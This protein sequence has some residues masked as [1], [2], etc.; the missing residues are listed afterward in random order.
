MKKAMR[1]FLPVLAIALVVAMSG[2]AFAQK[3]DP[4]DFINGTIDD[5]FTTNYFSNNGVAGAPHGTFRATNDGSTERSICANVYVFDDSQEMKECCSCLITP[6]GMRTWDINVDLN[7]S[8]A[9][10]R[11]ANQGLIQVISTDGGNPFETDTDVCDATFGINPFYGSS[12][13]DAQ[14]LEPELESWATH[15]QVSNLPSTKKPIVAATY[16]LTET[17]SDEEELSYDEYQFLPSEC[18]SI[19]NSEFGSGSGV[20]VCGCGFEL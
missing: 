4:G 18:A 8:P 1:I 14:E 11:V 5:V 2:A 20:G 16:S 3:V 17:A 6:D 12:N 10:G 9:N 15:V 13:P 19:T 7:S